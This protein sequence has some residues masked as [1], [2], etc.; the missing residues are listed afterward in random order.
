MKGEAG[1]RWVGNGTSQPELP[2]ARRGRKPSA[3]PTN[4]P[5]PQGGRDSPAPHLMLCELTTLKIEEE[6]SVA[7]HV[8]R[9]PLQQGVGVE[10]P[11]PEV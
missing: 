7:L 8:Q 10:G 9:I 3:R 11:V 6:Y 2:P 1:R 4:R 5:P